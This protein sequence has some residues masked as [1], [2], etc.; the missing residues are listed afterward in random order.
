[1][2]H[3]QAD[4]DLDRNATTSTDSASSWQSSGVPFSR[5]LIMAQLN[6][7]VHVS[8]YIAKI[9][10]WIYFEGKQPNRL[11]HSRSPSIVSQL[12]MRRLMEEIEIGCCRLAIGDV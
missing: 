12:M 1:M 8:R 3:V 11:V 7:D 2:R 6:R 4:V 10:K 9:Q 5:R